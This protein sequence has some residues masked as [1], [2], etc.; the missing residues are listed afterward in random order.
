MGGAETLRLRAM[1][2]KA[3]DTKAEE[4]ALRAKRAQEAS[5]RAWRAKELAAARAHEEKQR[6]LKIARN[7]QMREKERKLAEQAQLEKLEFERILQVQAEADARDR[8]Q[9]E[10]KHQINVNHSKEIREIIARNEIERKVQRQQFLSEGDKLKDR[11]GLEQS[12]V[13][14][15]KQRKL[16]ELEECGVPEKYRA[17][18][19]RY[20]IEG[21]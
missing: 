20:K 17:E 19:E 12:K 15:I 2:E 1:Q 3:A 18:L 5:E 13:E 10:V 6:A 21:Y 11:M 9:M 16:K 14:L 4:D 7:V 8:E